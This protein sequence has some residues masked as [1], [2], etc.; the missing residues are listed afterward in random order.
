MKI[1]PENLYR[2]ALGHFYSD[3]PSAWWLR[4]LTRLACTEAST[5]NHESMWHAIARME[6]LRD[7]EE[8]F[9]AIEI[10]GEPSKDGVRDLDA[11][12]ALY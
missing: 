8:R 10:Y 4:V 7:I 9:W 1:T 5:E 2:E 11:T 12:M 6:Q 3:Q